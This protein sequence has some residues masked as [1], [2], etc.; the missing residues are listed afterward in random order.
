ML[1]QSHYFFFEKQ[2]GLTTVSGSLL[3]RW[4]PNSYALFHP[5]ESQSAPRRKKKKEAPELRR[6]VQKK[7]GGGGGAAVSCALHGDSAVM[8]P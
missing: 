8:L 1:K 6:K 7:M 2:K 4:E 5:R 3:H